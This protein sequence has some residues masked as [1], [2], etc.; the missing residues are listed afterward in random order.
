M[1]AGQSVEE[2]VLNMIGYIE[3]MERMGLGLHS[4]LYI[5]LIL[6]SLTTTFIPFIDNLMMNELEPELPKLLKL[7]KE[8]EDNRSRRAPALVLDSSSPKPKVK[9]KSKNLGPK[10]TVKKGKGKGKTLPSK[11]EKMTEAECFFC[12]KKGH[13][14]RNCASDTTQ[15][16]Y[17]LAQD[18]LS[19]MHTYN[20]M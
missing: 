20:L 14:K 8:F 2:H 10:K 11:K 16:L 3:D 4:V 1:A 12:L 13:W 15:I 7:L 17:I 5:D 18:S 6:K 19:F 9:G